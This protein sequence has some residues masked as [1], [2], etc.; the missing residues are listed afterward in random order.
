M[1]TIRREHPSLTE[2]RSHVSELMGLTIA[3]AETAWAAHGYDPFTV[4]PEEAT[5]AWYVRG[6]AMRITSPCAALEAGGI[7]LTVYAGAADPPGPSPSSGSGGGERLQTEPCL[8]T[9]L[10][11]L[12]WADG[13][14]EPIPAIAALSQPSTLSPPT[15]TAAIHASPDDGGFLANEFSGGQKYFVPAGPTDSSSTVGTYA[16]AAVTAGR[17]YQ[18]NGLLADESGVG[19]GDDAAGLSVIWMGGSYGSYTFV[20]SELNIGLAHEPR[21]TWTAFSGVFTAPSGATAVCVLINYQ[22]ELGQICVTEIA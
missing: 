1:T 11:C 5:D 9:E 13:E 8:N 20:D 6:H 17:L 16:L 12:S 14:P 15:E 19:S 7:A 10:I 4:Q 2:F 21:P 22:A 3:A 18:F